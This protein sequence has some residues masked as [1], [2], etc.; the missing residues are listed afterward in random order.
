MK[1]N[2]IEHIKGKK[3]IGIE[4]KYV[5]EILS[6]YLKN[7]DFAELLNKDRKQILKNRKFKHLVK[8]IRKELY[9]IHGLYQVRKQSKKKDLLN[10]LSQTK[11]INQVK[12]ISK[13]IL[14]Q[15]TSS[16][17]RINDYG[18][19][20]AKILK[21]TKPKSI[22]DLASGL[23]PC[24][25]ILSSFKGDYYAYEIS[26]SDVNFLNKYFKIIKKY[27][28]NGKSFV[29]NIAKEFNFKK[30][31]VCFLFKF[32]DLMGKERKLFFINLIKHLDCKYLV[33][34][35]SKKTIS[36]KAMR[37]PERKWF[38][39]LLTNL[40]LKYKKL[41]FENEIFYLIKLKIL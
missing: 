9:N 17:E 21:I 40:G 34:S 8:E 29:K 33:A 30:A 11:N 2:L 39:S 4:D 16:R 25:I 12:D 1:K 27:N 14:G 6:K 26:R 37:N 20:Y 32:L 5:I 22:I 24:S 28:I 41:D 18:I 15:H 13:E 23:N 19:I 7:K 3:N 10:S 35:F 31:D 36:L 38:E